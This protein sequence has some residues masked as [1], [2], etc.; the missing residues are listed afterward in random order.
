M[1]SSLKAASVDEYK[2]LREKVAPKCTQNEKLDENQMGCF[3]TSNLT[4]NESCMEIA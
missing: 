4:L 1:G 3:N 2:N